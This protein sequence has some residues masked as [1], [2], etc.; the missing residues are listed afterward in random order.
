MKQLLEQ[1]FT[2]KHDI[3][4]NRHI[5]RQQLITGRQSFGDP[6]ACSECSPFFRS[7]GCDNTV[8]KAS[9]PYPVNKI[10]IEEFINGFSKIESRRCDLLF[11]DNDKI[12]LADMYCGKSDYI[13]EH[14]VDGKP[15][16]GKKTIVRQQ[17]ESTLDLLCSVEPIKEFIYSKTKKTGI[18]AYRDKYEAH[19]DD[20]P[21]K[22]RTSVGK[23]L[24]PTDAQKRRSLIT[25]IAHG[26]SYISCRYPDVYQW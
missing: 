22:I 15:V 8:F 11:W 14:S 13:N 19:F 2:P 25:A 18:M 5:A 16:Q 26:F 9:F 1:D 10:E 23:F 12:V 7:G 6:K 3:S 20:A 24:R 4:G 21:A 17:I